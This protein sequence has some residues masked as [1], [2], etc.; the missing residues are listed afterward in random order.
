MFGVIREHSQLLQ[1]PSQGLKM[2]QWKTGHII[3]C[4]NNFKLVFIFWTFVYFFYFII[5]IHIPY[6]RSII[7]RIFSN[8]NTEFKLLSINKFFDWYFWWSWVLDQYTKIFN[9]T[10]ANFFNKVK[11]L[12][13]ASSWHATSIRTPVWHTLFSFPSFNW[14]ALLFIAARFS[15]IKDFVMVDNLFL[16][17]FIGNSP[18]HQMRGS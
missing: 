16:M 1:G 12:N 9:L 7:K 15:L 8:C 2:G 18:P 17:K 3:S 11:F 6:C 4:L 10:I 13:D 14:R 5:L